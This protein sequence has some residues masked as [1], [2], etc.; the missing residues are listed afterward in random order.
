MT[1][2]ERYHSDPKFREELLAKNKARREKKKEHYCA[3]RR[4][5]YREHSQIQRASERKRRSVLKANFIEAYGGCTEC[6]CKEPEFCVADHVND[7]G[8]LLRKSG[9]HSI[10]TSLYKWA[11]DNSYPP[12]L[13]CLCHNHNHKKE[14]LRIGRGDSD[15]AKWKRRRRAEAMHAYGSSCQCCGESDIDML[16]IDHVYG[17]GANQRRE[18]TNSRFYI[19]LRDNNFPDG[20]Q[21]LCANCNASK[22]YGGG[23]CIHKR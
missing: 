16:Q 14:I 12:M 7:D 10:S 3:V 11:R 4:E 20:Y 1:R 13:Q 5:W 8:G 22:H 17:N 23:V 15:A 18:M 9:K 6:G 19:W 21:T 2:T